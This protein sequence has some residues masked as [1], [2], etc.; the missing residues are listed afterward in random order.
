MNEILVALIMVS[1]SL[2]LLSIVIILL[3]ALYR[4][5]HQLVSRLTR[6][7]AFGVAV[8]F[9]EA[10][11]N[12]SNAIRSYSSEEIKIS[13]EELQAILRRAQQ[14]RQRLQ[15]KRILWVDDSPYANANIHRFLND[16]GVT[17]DSVR[18]TQ[19]ALNTLHWAH[20]AY[21]LIISDMNRDGNGKAGIELLEGIAKLAEN[22][23]KLKDKPVILFISNFDPKLGTPPGA[24][25][26][27][28]NVQVLLSHVFDVL[29]RLHFEY[30]QD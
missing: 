4:P 30:A 29:D 11:R 18:T 15:G 26:I 25:A 1:P 24:R 10:Q 5:L 17:V 21:E 27:T 16:F 8:E 23:P 2:C 19:D 20:T 13:E 7:D 12:L 14:M 6:L 28:N 22:K 3:I 9:G